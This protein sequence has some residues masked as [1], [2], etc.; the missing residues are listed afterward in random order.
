MV[1]YLTIHS[2]SYGFKCLRKVHL[3]APTFLGTVVKGKK[4]L[5]T[6]THGNRNCFV[7]HQQ[8]KVHY[9]PSYSGKKQFLFAD[10]Q[11]FCVQL[12][13]F[14][15]RFLPFVLSFALFYKQKNL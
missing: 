4:P 10:D 15:Y 12:L 9:Y 2:F 14:S 6:K 7:G 5:I 8:T 11:Q 1:A 13:G 3:R